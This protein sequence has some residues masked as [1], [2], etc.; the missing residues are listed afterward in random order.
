MMGSDQ[1]PL[2][3][4]ANPANSTL[5]ELWRGRDDIIIPETD[6]GKDGVEPRWDC[7]LSRN[8]NGNLSI[9]IL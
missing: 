6:R 5:L 9:N 4:A 1:E 7:V 3:A 8:V 2:P